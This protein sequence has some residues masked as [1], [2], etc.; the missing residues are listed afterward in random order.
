[1][2]SLI[3]YIVQETVLFIFVYQV[4]C[5]L[6]RTSVPVILISTSQWGQLL[7]NW[8]NESDYNHDNSCFVLMQVSFLENKDFEI[9][10]W[11][12]YKFMEKSKAFNSDQLISVLLRK[13]RTVKITF[14]PYINLRNGWKY[15]TPINY[16]AIT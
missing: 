12:L 10:I 14:G 1:M 15:M 9:Y 2:Y 5:A 16:S 6:T 4:I 7:R 11:S 8:L 3:N 13:M